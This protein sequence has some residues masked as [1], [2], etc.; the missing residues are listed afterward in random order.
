MSH[1]DELRQLDAAAAIPD[2][3]ER[4]RVLSRLVAEYESLVR[5]AAMLRR[6]AITDALGAGM[7]QDQVARE[8][9]V[10]PGRVSQM[11]KAATGKI[12]ATDTEP[13]ITGW[14]T[15][16]DSPAPRV[17]ICGSRSAGTNAEA[18][19]AAVA[20]LTELLM[21]QRYA[22]SHG[23]VGI[24][25]ETLTRIAD[26]H[27]PAGLDTVRG[28]IGHANVIK[29]ADYVVVIGGGA[30][31]QSEIDTAISAGKQVLPM[32]ASGGAAARTYMRMLSDPPLRAWLTDDEFSA[33]ATADAARF[34]EIIE[35]AITPGEVTP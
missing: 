11:R 35:T 14:R 34:A 30:G 5:S 7:T 17:A 26:Q 1:G 27:H 22:V 9:G 19:D 2:P 13:V 23:P 10:T 25:A 20:S 16:G 32:P 6:E 12:T 28:I 31:T 21:R 18:I 33:L 8:I 3:M 15:P 4:A 24:G 29:D